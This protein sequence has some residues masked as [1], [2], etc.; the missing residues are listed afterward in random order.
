MFVCKQDNSSIS[1]WLKFVVDNGLFTG[2]N[3]ESGPNPSHIA[4]YLVSENGLE[5]VA[6]TDDQNANF[7]NEPDFVGKPYVD[8]EFMYFFYRETAVEAVNQGKFV[9]SRVGRLCLNDTGHNK[10]FQTFFKVRLNCSLQGEYPFYFDHIQDVIVEE[11]NNDVIFYAVFTTTPHGPASSAVCS[12]RLTDIKNV[13]ATSKFKGKE[14][15]KLPGP[16]ERPAYDNRFEQCL[17]NELNS[18]TR[19]FQET[20]TLMD[21]L[22]PNYN[23]FHHSNDEFDPPLLYSTG[24]NFYSFAVD[25]DNNITFVG[26]ES[27]TILQT[28]FSNEEK[29]ETFEIEILNMSRPVTGLRH[30]GTKLL[31]VTAKGLYQI[32]LENCASGCQKE[33]ERF[34]HSYCDCEKDSKYNDG[35]VQILSSASNITSCVNRKVEL[36]CEVQKTSPFCENVA[37]NWYWSMKGEAYEPLVTCSETE[38]QGDMTMLAPFVQYQIISAQP[39]YK[40]VHLTVTA[41]PDT[42]GMF[43]CEVDENTKATVKLTLDT[44]NGC[45]TRDSYNERSDHRKKLED[46]KTAVSECQGNADATKIM[47]QECDKCPGDPRVNV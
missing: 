28:D 11:R 35:S 38:C 8:G 31:A 9:Y 37:L 42:Q 23:R 20:N 7:V 4:R 39:H 6:T 10:E 46:E 24:M 16:V 3:I 12:Y 36:T 2:Y 1:A 21:D 17:V 5:E 25:S 33:C 19:N 15:N 14:A 18:Q 34:R 32:E 41:L 26:T 43:I 29:V 13:F 40:L 44:S 22:V 27:G 45:L 47:F 30:N